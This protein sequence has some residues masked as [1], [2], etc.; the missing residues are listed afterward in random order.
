MPK[1]LQPSVELDLKT[2]LGLAFR[3]ALPYGLA[4]IAAGAV[5]VG[6]CAFVSP[7][8]AQVFGVSWAGALIVLGY[9][10]RRKDR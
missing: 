9:G 1:L 6:L 3:Y 8:C 5:F 7:T 4:T 2:R 10:L